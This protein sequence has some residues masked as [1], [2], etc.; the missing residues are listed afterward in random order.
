MQEV[1]RA[2]QANAT[3]HRSLA[4]YMAF[5]RKQATRKHPGGRVCLPVDAERL[6]LV[7]NS[8]TTPVT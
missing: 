1:W 6:P 7:K 5:L 8:G 3:K 4:A 2:K